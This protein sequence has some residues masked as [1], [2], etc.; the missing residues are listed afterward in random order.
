MCLRCGK[1]Q[2]CLC[3]LFVTSSRWGRSDSSFGCKTHASGTTVVLHSNTAHCT[4]CNE[5]CAA[6][7]RSKVQCWHVTSLL[8]LHSLQC[9]SVNQCIYVQ[10]MIAQ[11]IVTRLQSRIDTMILWV[12]CCYKY[13][14]VLHSTLN[15]RS[16]GSLTTRRGWSDA[17][18][19][20]LLQNLS[21]QISSARTHMLS[22][23][24]ACSV[25]EESG[26]LQHHRL[27]CTQLHATPKRNQSK[28]Q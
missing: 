9:R 18:C 2:H 17:M 14:I 1:Y 8:S 20:L 13:I 19:I 16:A 22:S 23:W 24:L 15:L 3:C 11:S 10:I 4:A 28:G 27:S 25:E 26:H 6:E 21:N 12:V 7:L 5:D